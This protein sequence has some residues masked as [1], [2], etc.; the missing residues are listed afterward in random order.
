MSFS[1]VAIADQDTFR[2]GLMPSIAQFTI[3]DP[4]G[5][6]AKGKSVSLLNAVMF[7]NVTRDDRVMLIV[8]SN[9][10]SVPA[11]STLIG[12]DVTR[13]DGSVSYQTLFRLSRNFKPM[14]GI[15]IGSA[16]ETYKNRYKLSPGGF[17]IA[18][19]PVERNI[20]N[21]YYVLNAGHEWEINR[22]WNIGLNLQYERPVSEI[23]TALKLGIY[24]T[25]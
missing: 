18:Q 20:N 11:S 24:L 4:S 8:G 9:K 2:F 5:Q 6:T 25:F 15:G 23:S 13:L 12:E 7:I 16:A 10:Y 19:T 3:N 22:T 17:G 1:S 21:F 14:L